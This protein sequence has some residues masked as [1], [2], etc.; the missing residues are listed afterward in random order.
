MKKKVK[1]TRVSVEIR[2]GDQVGFSLRQIALVKREGLT[3]NSPL[4]SENPCTTISPMYPPSLGKTS[5][6]STLEVDAESRVERR[7]VSLSGS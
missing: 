1:V 6:G 3:K 5:L 4:E 7:M 2:P